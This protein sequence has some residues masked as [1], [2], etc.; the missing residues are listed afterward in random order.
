M[1]K[2]SNNEELQKTFNEIAKLINLTELYSLKRMQIVALKSQQALFKLSLQ[3]LP[4]QRKAFLFALVFGFVAAMSAGIG[5]FVVG[6]TLANLGIMIGS[7]VVEAAAFVGFIYLL[8]TYKRVRTEKKVV[9]D[10]VKAT[11]ASL[12]G[13]DDMMN[14]MEQDY[15]KTKQETQILLEKA[16]HQLKPQTK[17]PEKE[18]R[19]GV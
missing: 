8:L 11:D 1:K 12:H 19:V 14:E 5:L 7:V 16:R 10:E 15:I 18:T 13:L 2:G 17:L 6:I 9:A 3:E 4:E